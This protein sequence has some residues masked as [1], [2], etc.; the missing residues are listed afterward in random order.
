MRRR[1][2]FGR[3]DVVVPESRGRSYVILDQSRLGGPETLRTIQVNAATVI[4]HYSASEARPR[5]GPGHLHGPSKSA[6]TRWTLL[7]LL[8]ALQGDT[9]SFAIADFRFASGE[10][11]A[12]P[13]APL[14]HAGTARA[15]RRGIVRTP[16]S[17]CTAPEGP[18]TQFLSPLFAGELSAAASRSTRPLIISSCG[19]HRQDRSSKPSE[20]LKAGSRTHVRG[21]GRGAVPPVTEGCTSITWCWSNGHVHGVHARVALAER[22]PDFM[23]GVVGSRCAP[24]ADRGPEPMMRSMIMEDIRGDPEWRNGDYVQQPPG[25]SPPCRFCFSWAEPAPPAA[26]APTRDSADA[27]IARWLRDRLAGAVRER[28]AVSVRGVARLRPDPISVAS[29][30]R[31]SPSI[32]RTT[33]STPGARD[34]GAL[35]PRVNRALRPDSDERRDARSRHPHRPAAWKQYFAPFV[36]SLERS[37]GAPGPG[38]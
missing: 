16:C 19:Q 10:T 18:G 15:R 23:D 1:P 25:S 26:C 20:R 24:R 22:H 12:G 27:Y 37:R 2:R 14:S 4:R 17:F 38:R 13:A 32:P 33:S 8:A 28:H 35:M 7:L 29:R 11:P 30:L 5:F 36:A 34:R 9:A 21:H 3:P 6:T 31:S